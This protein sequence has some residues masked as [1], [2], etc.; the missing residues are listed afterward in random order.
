MK[1]LIAEDENDIR[2]LV[3]FAFERNGFE[4]IE[5]RDGKEALSLCLE[6]LPD[7]ILLD[8]MMPV[9]DGYQV[10]QSLKSNP[11]TSRIPV[12]FLSAR[13]RNLE[14]A[15]GF[16]RGA[17]A[18]IVKPFDPKALVA[19]IK[20]VMQEHAAKLDEHKPSEDDPG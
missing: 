14:I 16:Q 20:K 12:V 13:G 19:Q 3:K 1:L 9:M 10:C 15:Q 2:N 4:V 17:A 18:Y 6:Q 8:V 7:I 11:A 5:A